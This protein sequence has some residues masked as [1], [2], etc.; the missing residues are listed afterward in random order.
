MRHY[1]AI[2]L[3]LDSQDPNCTS[4]HGTGQ[5]FQFQPSQGQTFIKSF[6]ILGF[7][8]AGYIGTNSCSARVFF[9]PN[10]VSQDVGKEFIFFLH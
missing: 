10:S 2:F 9:L 7:K 6:V 1:Y 3:V 5:F 8:I 4:V